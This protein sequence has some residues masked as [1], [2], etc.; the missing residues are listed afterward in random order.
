[1]RRLLPAFIV[2]I[3]CIGFA[4]AQTTYRSLQLSQ[5]TSGG[6]SVDT[7]LGIYFPGHILS[8]TTGFGTQ[9]QP[10]PTIGGTGTPTLAGTDSAGTITMGTS[11]TTA[12]VTFGRAYI[13]VPSCIVSW[14]SAS[15]GTYVQATTSLAITQIST[16]GNKISYFCP[17]QN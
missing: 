9:N 2:T 4:L 7:N 8:P 6:F 3:L 13:S 5:D 11:A 16:S 10:L 15:P 17:S 14:N 12:T 1:M